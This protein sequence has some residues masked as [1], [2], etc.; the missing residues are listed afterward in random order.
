MRQ[1]MA[2]G[3]PYRADDPELVDLA[4]RA[5]DLTQAYNATSA[6][7]G[8]RRWALLVE[9]LAAVGDGT[10]V[11]PPLRVDYG[12]H[13]SIGER[14]FVNYGLVALDVAA[15]SIGDDVQIGSNV[16][17]LTPMHPLA[18]GPAATSGSPLNRSPSRTTCGWAVG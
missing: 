3:E 17:L 12:R 10:E 7:A 6:R 4:L 14:T 1:R 13:I 15:I 11:R 9:L 16:Q 2:A 8:E 5:S 18:A